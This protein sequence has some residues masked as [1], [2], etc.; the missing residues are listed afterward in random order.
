MESIKYDYSKLL[1]RIREL[2]L[3]QANVAA[4]AHI[5]ETTLRNKLKSETYFS[6]PQIEAIMQMLHIPLSEIEPYFF[7][8]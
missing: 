7:T 8:H 5:S 2:H 6:V 3:T 1:G 4:F